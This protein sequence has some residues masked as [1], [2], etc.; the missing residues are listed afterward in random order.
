MDTRFNFRL[1]REA[2]LAFHKYC[3]EKNI[4]P[5]DLLRDYIYDILSKNGVDCS[6]FV[7]YRPN[8]PV[9]DKPIPLGMRY[10]VLSR[11]NFKCTL[12]GE[13]PATNPKIKLHV[14]HII[15]KVKGGETIMENL[16]SVC[17]DCNLGKGTDNVLT[18]TNNNECEHVSTP[19]KIIF[20]PLTGE[21]LQ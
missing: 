12:C 11:D 19:K 21:P 13:S 17:S 16:W 1:D 20:D 2:L 10:K 4:I 15:S 6:K 7:K 9:K 5:S 18:S 14:D 8:T 3:I